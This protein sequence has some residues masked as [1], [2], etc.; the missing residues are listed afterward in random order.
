M[1][2]SKNPAMVTHFSHLYLKSKDITSTHKAQ[3]QFTV[4]KSLAF[5]SDPAPFLPLG[6]SERSADPLAPPGLGS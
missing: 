3:K 1:A 4:D 5:Q 6:P 2:V